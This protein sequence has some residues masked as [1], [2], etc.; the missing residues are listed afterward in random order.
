MVKGKISTLT[1]L[2]Y[3]ARSSGNKPLYT[4]LSHQGKEEHTI[5]YAQLVN[6]AE[7]IAFR[8]ARD[9]R[10]GDRA[11]LIFPPGIGFITSFYAVVMAGM[12][13]VPV[14]PPRPNSSSDRLTAI[15]DRCQGAIVLTL[16]SWVSK[17]Q[18][19]LPGSVTVIAV[20]DPDVA[21]SGIVTL[22]EISATD[23]VMIQFTSGSTATPKGVVLTHE[24]ILQNQLLIQQAFGQ[25]DNSIIVSWLPFYHDMGLMGSIIHT[26]YVGASAVMFPP[27]DFLMKPILWLE[28][29]SRYKGTVSGAPN[30]AFQLCVDRIS[31]DELK[32][33]DLSGWE[34]AYCGAEPINA[35]TLSA[36]A[37]KFA[38]AGFNEKAL[39]PCYG[40]AETTL[41]IA[42]SPKN[43]GYS[44]RKK[45]FRSLI[46]E[47]GT[48]SVPV[49]A[50]VVNCGR[51]T[52][53]DLRIIDADKHE[54]AEGVVG[55]IWVRGASVS[56][57]YWNDDN[58]AGGD[59]NKFINGN[60]PYLNT[61]DLGFIEG[62]DLYITGRLKELIIINGRNYYPTD[63]ERSAAAVHKTLSS[64][65]MAAFSVLQDRQEKLVLVCE[66]SNTFKPD[67]QTI[68][69]DIRRELSASY[70]INAYDILL[71]RKNSLPRT[72]SGKIQR[73][74]CRDL[75]M[76]SLFEP[77]S[78]V[79]VEM[80]DG[81][82]TPLELTIR[83]T[84]EQVTGRV[85]E[86]SHADLFSLGLDSLQLARLTISLSKAL[87]KEIPLDLIFSHPDIHS[88]AN[89]I[90]AIPFS[91][92]EP[93]PSGQSVYYPLSPVQLGIWYD[94]NLK[95]NSSYN[96]PCLLTLEEEPD[97]S[98]LSANLNRLVSTFE[99]LRTIFLLQPDGPIQKVLPG[100]DHHIGRLDLSLLAP[101]E[102]SLQVSRLSSRIFEPDK[103]PL[104]S[105]TIIKFPGNIF[106]ILAVF[107]HLIADGRSVFL[108][109][110]ALLQ[111]QGTLAGE[112]TAADQRS[113]TSYR[114]YVKWQEHYKQ[115]SAFLADKAYWIKQFDQVENFV[116]PFRDKATVTSRNGFTV[117][118]ELTADQCR[119][120][121]ELSEESSA[122]IYTVLLTSF[123]LLLSGISQRNQVIVGVPTHGRVMP[124][125]M[126]AM[127]VFINAI[128]VKI[129]IG[130]NDTAVALIKKVSKV[131]NDGL[132]HQRSSFNDVLDGW[133]TKG[134]SSSVNGKTTVFFN[135]LN[136]LNDPLSERQIYE[137]FQEN[138][139]V[140]MNLDINSY[141]FPDQDKLR[142]RM[143]C[144]PAKISRSEAERLIFQYRYIIGKMLDQPGMP[145]KPVI[146]TLPVDEPEYRKIL[147]FSNG[148]DV[149]VPGLHL[150][151]QIFRHVQRAPDSAAYLYKDSTL[152][153][154]QLWLKSEAVANELRSGMLP[155]GTLI[156]VLTGKTPDLP[157]A[158]LGCLKA[159]A[160]Y[161]PFDTDW[162]RERILTLLK[163]LAAPV[164][165]VDGDFDTGSLREWSD[166]A[167]N[168]TSL[169]SPETFVE[170]EYGFDP[171]GIIYGI[172]TSGTTGQP[173]CALNRHIGVM[174][175]FSDM[176]ARFNGSGADTILFTSKQTF[177]ASFWQMCWPLTLGARIV[178]AGSHKGFDPAE[179]AEVIDRHQVTITDFVPSVFNLLVEYLN[180]QPASSITFNSLRHI[181][182]G[183]EVM[184]LRYVR[185]FMKKYPR[186]EITNTYGPTEA[187]MAVIF[188]K[189]AYDSTDPIPIGKPMGNVRVVLL[190]NNHTLTPFGSI[191]EICLGGLCLG[192]GY[193]NLPEK[194][195]EVFIDNP[196]PDIKS[197]KLY[198]TGDLGYFLPD[199]TLQFAGRVDDQVKVN[200]IRIELGEIEN[201]LISIPGIERAVLSA[202]RKDERTEICAYVIT[203]GLATAEIRKALGTKLPDYMIPAHIIEIKEIPV[204][205]NGKLDRSR[206]PIPDQ[207][208]ET[209][210]V[211][212]PQNNIE[213]ELLMIFS[214]LLK[215]PA[216]DISTNAD[217]FMIGGNSLTATRLQFG[218]QDT[219]QKS[220][221]LKDIF[222]HPTI[223][224]LAAVVKA[225]KN[226]TQDIELPETG[227]HFNL[228]AG[229][230]RLW[231][232][233]QLENS[234]LALNIPALMEINGTV[235]IALLNKILYHLVERY[236]ILRTVFE[237]ID[238]Q[239]MQRVLDHPAMMRPFEV[240]D[241]QGKGNGIIEEQVKEK[242][243]RPFDIE[244]GPLYN[245]V[246]FCIG[247]DHFYLLLNMH[248]LITDAWSLELLMEEFVTMYNAPLAVETA[249]LKEP[250]QY[251]H[252]VAMKEKYR[253][254]AGHEQDKLYWL[255]KF[256]KGIPSLD[257]PCDYR[258]AQSKTYNGASA[259][260]TLE[261]HLVDLLKDYCTEHQ[262]TTF[263]FLTAAINVLLYKY[264]SQTDIAIRFPVS[265]RDYPE[266]QHQIGF[267]VNTL[268]LKTAFDTHYSFDNLLA[269]V[270]EELLDAFTHQQFEFI[271]LLREL[272]M[273]KE[274]SREAGLEVSILMEDMTGIDRSL[275]QL[276]G[277]TFA[278]RNLARDYVISDLSFIIREGI[279]SANITVEYNT[280][281][282]SS[283]KVL[284]MIKHLENIVEAVLE[285]PGILLSGICYLEDWETALLINRFNETD[286]AYPGHR[287]VVDLFEEQAEKDPGQLAIFRHGTAISYQQLNELSDVMCALIEA[288]ADKLGMIVPII[289]RDPLQMIVGMLAVLKSGKAYMPVD[290]T[291]PEE[292][293]AVMIAD[294]GS[295]LALIE[296]QAELPAGTGIE[297]IPLIIQTGARDKAP[298]RKRSLRTPDSL[299]YVMYTSG[300]TGRPKGIKGID[301]NVVRLVRNTNLISLSAGDRVLQ[302]SP[303]T[304]DPSVMEIWGALLN[305]ATLYLTE[306]ESVLNPVALRQELQ[307]HSITFLWLT[308]PVFHEMASLDAVMFNG[309]RQLV[310]GGDI[311]LPDK[312]NRVIRACPQ[313]KLTN[314]YG[315]TEN[316]VFS[317][318]LSLSEEVT[319]S[320]SIG[321]PISN[322]KVYILDS[323]LK[324][325]PVGVTGNMY[326]GGAGIPA[327]YHDEALTRERFIEDPFMKNRIIYD[328]G[329]LA[330]WMDDG[331][332]DFLGRKDRQFKVSGVRIE[333]GEIESLLN[334]FPGVRN[335][336]VVHQAT[337]IVAYVVME[338]DRFDENAIRN[339]LGRY[340]VGIMI[341]GY[342]IRIEE[343]PFTINGK[344]NVSA[345]PTPQRSAMIFPA[346]SD[347]VQLKLRKIWA[348]VLEINEEKIGARQDF[349]D[350][351]GNSL[352]MGRVISRIKE[353]FSMTISYRDLFTHKDIFS[354]ATLMKSKQRTGKQEEPIPVLNRS[355]FQAN[356]I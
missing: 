160:A 144:N 1:D 115:S 346:P 99:V 50:A 284:R 49:T 88:F 158:I 331:N 108:F 340:L 254:G 260:I 195:R 154:G 57:G 217:F 211:I 29:M 175:R 187:A 174:N 180:R 205:A 169:L 268:I 314:A 230:H 192:A 145:L 351:G 170:R 327:G 298:E 316:G 35:D 308:T 354:I 69:S 63:I 328:T 67:L 234:S 344:V 189:V 226:N 244:N 140:E 277:T 246:L 55:E 5:T 61:G 112:I 7:H 185:Q 120:I 322:S 80:V 86:N 263:M 293:I 342:I 10:K 165:L 186:I 219:F 243:N 23:T 161:V 176:T 93:V 155:P 37:R 337:G 289:A 54:A 107:H 356:N 109:M 113:R 339:Y 318:C 139:G 110:K 14:N 343:M 213:E 71:V 114:E 198:K 41:L 283:H 33:I 203:E 94:F 39:Q 92:Q 251:R 159:G 296:Q 305:G 350:L 326:V 345:L 79:A 306:K 288:K 199:G 202:I 133:R 19:L 190:R 307:A 121:K 279:S 73:I 76:R 28:L 225:S 47:G 77:L 311:L 122:N 123:S 333:P 304:F 299:C 223:E 247:T 46:Y 330:R 224:K 66:V 135:G 137:A 31:N 68:I 214:R 100:Y 334:G 143:D 278:R 292:R 216:E 102:I 259:N 130:E 200:G 201:V 81:T 27:V 177:D 82:F 153:Y 48:T 129:D 270:K 51:P 95:K 85:P 106:K 212:K 188:H 40:M 209:G 302:T 252:M 84:V 104:F 285:A 324:P 208:P 132:L 26:L 197:D 355:D 206:L 295:R 257:F 222:A 227:D 75:Y 312:V 249:P 168:V 228:S 17:V 131:L 266:A 194:T 235:D 332:I 241:L 13:A 30:F 22:P 273:N 16:S 164:I 245:P 59:F 136:F 98:Y 117:S 167:I 221:G 182:I 118:L 149:P 141:V 238:G 325:V 250:Y 218:I 276:N 256:S 233:N 282:L 220:V 64:D 97:D 162:P 34:S 128:M 335:S 62:G 297:L 204:N 111:G 280:A 44:V 56:K 291:F 65:R 148:S 15:V 310:T 18:Q 171:D 181:L 156:P 116:L 72:T 146:D 163:D 11:L 90:S 105:L 261:G 43:A 96:I 25:H 126:D 352:V 239:P 323:A 237:T 191:G 38:A 52:G 127:G 262:V 287:T 210:R 20:D 300:S 193:H 21:E 236:E 119:Q 255:K 53:F 231:L 173:K 320:V 166:R 60:G 87:K 281:L 184:S 290:P 329:D 183:G 45:E 24:N 138:P 253:A 147:Q 319:G 74:K 229:Q 32:G 315:P 274:A 321:R 36:F 150:L 157:I 178:I 265:G 134:L 317:T 103:G 301:R 83:N 347:P 303:L 179:M 258:P 309:L 272:A 58:A 264:T 125:F 207:I 353:E 196:F 9:F 336:Y 6:D 275:E 8:L 152:T 248:H 70:E 349:Y 341:P 42:A 286:T 12:I 294:S 267:F 338:A 232:L 215:C 4:F 91:I 271:E 89:A 124:A 240:I 142:I 78:P 242:V 269:A 151:T 348:E 2:L 313:L 172:Y 101:E 3:H